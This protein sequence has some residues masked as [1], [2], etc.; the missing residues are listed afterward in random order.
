VEDIRFDDIDRLKSKI[1]DQFSGWSEPVEITQDMIQKFADLTGDHQWIHV[2]VERAKRESP[3]KAPIAHG[4]LTLSCLP[5]MKREPEWRL[6]GYGNATN[7]G[8]NK[9]RFVSPVPA[10]SKIHSR[11]R[12][13]GVEPHP[14]G[15]QVT[16]EINVH[17]VGSEKPAL[18]YEMV[19]L[20][21]PPMKRG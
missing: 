11:G 12:L 20:Y 6:T 21:H 10:G 18:I 7:Y 9:L 1:S 4:F 2:D 5:A 3:F 15:T 13:V 16:Q 17:V 14:K 8:A 19:V